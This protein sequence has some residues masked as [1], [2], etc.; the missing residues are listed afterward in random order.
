MKCGFRWL[1]LALGLAWA[2]PV[3]AQD[4]ALPL[5]NGRFQV[6]ALYRTAT[7][8]GSGHA[9]ALT[10][11][12]GYF[13]FF[14]SSNVEVLVKVL[15]GCEPFQ[16]FWFFAAGLTDVEVTLRV[17]DTWA[18]QT[19]TYTNPLG[20][21][22][23]P[24]LDT[25]AFE[26]CGVPAPCG[27][28][29]AAEIAATPRADPDAELLALH[30]G[31]ELTAPEDL[32]QRIVSDLTVIRSVNPVAGFIPF[33]PSY[34]PHDFLFMMTDEAFA[35]LQSG[36]YHEWDCLNRWYG[37]DRIQLFNII[38]GGAVSFKGVFDMERVMADY[39]TLPGIRAVELNGIL[40][41]PLFEP[42]RSCA[43]KEGHAIRYFFNQGTSGNGFWEYVSDAPGVA[44]REVVPNVSRFEE[45]MNRY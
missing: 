33:T 24:I 9:V 8:E 3:L 1:P 5:L 34:T 20:R 18:N 27:Q 43:W 14:G 25:T 4:S 37:R 39:A 12:S 30:L 40:S 41:I 36:N 42:D 17:T 2:S 26:T 22:F 11:N 6:E 44:P 16:R 35:R 31:G 28:G 45:C 19:Q 23:A 15:D 32:Y 21:D 10:P 29:T 13:W 38:K 7:T